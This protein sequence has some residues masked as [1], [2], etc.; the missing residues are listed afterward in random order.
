MRSVPLRYAQK[1]LTETA[2]ECDLVLP[3]ARIWKKIMTARF[4]LAQLPRQSGG[5]R[6]QG[7]AKSDIEIYDGLAKTLG[8]KTDLKMYEEMDMLRTKR[9]LKGY[10]DFM[11]GRSLC[12]DRHGNYGETPR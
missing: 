10:Q 1:Y 2:K 5:R 8:L 9:G 4:I 7:K 3:A 11:N 6:T 12:T